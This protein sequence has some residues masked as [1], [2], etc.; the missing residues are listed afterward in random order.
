MH[1][2]PAGETSFSCRVRAPISFDFLW[3]SLVTGHIIDACHHGDELLELNLTVAVL[4]NLLD[5]LVDGLGA[6]R[7]GATE[8]ENLSDFVGGNNS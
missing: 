1:E 3:W 8:A 4:V 6:Q 5:D 2:K 7:V